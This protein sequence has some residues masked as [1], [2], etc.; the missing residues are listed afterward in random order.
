[1]HTVECGDQISGKSDRVKVC[2]ILRHSVTQAFS[3]KQS[4]Q[5]DEKRQMA[6]IPLEKT[7]LD[8]VVR[9]DP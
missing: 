1:M 6:S 9:R 4:A 8:F 7:A 3:I 5:L 2:V